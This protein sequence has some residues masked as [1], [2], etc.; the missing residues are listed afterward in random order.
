MS[1]YS[2][3]VM[4]KKP[5]SEKLD[6]NDRR[7]G[8]TALPSVP[9]RVDGAVASCSAESSSQLRV[10]ASSNLCEARRGGPKPSTCAVD[11]ED[12]HGRH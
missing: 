7:R 8:R 4:R 3:R 5:P 6:F 10:V 9:E 2:G 1:G 12:A 11:S